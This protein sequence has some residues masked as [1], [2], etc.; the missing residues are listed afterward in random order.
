MKADQWNWGEKAP[1]VLVWWVAALP[2]SRMGRC[3]FWN[4]WRLRKRMLENVKIIWGILGV[5]E[6]TFVRDY[7]EYEWFEEWSCS[8]TSYLWGYKWSFSWTG[9]MCYLY[10]SMHQWSLFIIAF[11]WSVVIPYSSSFFQ[12]SL[13][14]KS[15]RMFRAVKRLN[16]NFNIWMWI[17]S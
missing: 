7:W 13:K 1:Y 14:F 12:T 9:R 16:F 10:S 4:S 8:L 17:K 11:L 15:E 6:R 3:I 2:R 5:G